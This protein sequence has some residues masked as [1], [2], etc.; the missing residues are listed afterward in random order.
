MENFGNWTV[1]GWELAEHMAIGLS[2]FA[3]SMAIGVNFYKDLQAK[4][5]VLPPQVY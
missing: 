5:G 2:A 3:G 1:S 4:I